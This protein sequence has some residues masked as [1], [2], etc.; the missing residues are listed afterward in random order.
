MNEVRITIGKVFAKSECITQDLLMQ[1]ADGKLS[2]ADARQVELH[3]VDCI[4]C[5]EALD[6]ILLAGTENYAK[7]VEEVGEL[8]EQRVSEESEGDAKVIEFRPNIN[9]PQ[10]GATPTATTPKGGFKKA[11]PFIGIAASV[12]L[13]LTFGIFFMGDSTAKIADRNFEA[14]QMGTRSATVVESPTDAG[15]PATAAADATFEEAM[16]LYKSKQY[17]A[18]A[19]KFDQSANPKAALFAGDSYFLLE[20]FSAAAIRYQKVIDAQNG[21]EDHAEYNLALTFLQLD[22]VDKAKAILERISQ[23]E[24]HNFV[25]KAKATLAEL[26]DL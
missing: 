15:L 21:S 23:N 14:M 3:L 13:I 8:V 10:A 9:P 6:G 17:Q 11:L 16:D 12:A 5:D 2:E 20:N 1:Y 22:Q 4:D 18:A 26:N 7:M 24:E 19:T 25:T